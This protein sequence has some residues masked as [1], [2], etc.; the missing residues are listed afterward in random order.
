MKRKLFFKMFLKSFLFTFCVALIVLF[1]FIRI[2]KTQYLENINHK[3]LNI[4]SAVETIIQTSKITKNSNDIQRVITSIDEKTGIRITIINHNGDVLADS[5]KNAEEMENHSD[6]PEFK[7]ALE[8]GYGNAIRWSPTIDSYMIYCAKNIAENSIVIRASIPVDKAKIALIS[9]K[10]KILNVVLIALFFGIVFS[11]LLAK[12]ATEPIYEILDFTEE[13]KSGRTPDIIINNKIQEIHKIMQNLTNF[14]GEMANFAK[15]E[16][17]VSEELVKFI[18]LVNFPIG[19]IDIKGDVA[20]SNSYF[21]EI[22]EIPETKGLWWEKIKNFDILKIIREVN[23]TKKTIEREIKIKDKT[24]LCKSTPLEE[25]EQILVVLIDISTIKD[26]QERK[27]DF[28]IAVSHELKTPLTAIKGY[29]ETIEENI[30]N[31]EN[32]K[33]L[34]IVKHHSERLEK[35]V[36]DLITLAQ[37]ENE[38]PVVEFKKVDII[39]IANNAISLFSKKAMEKGIKIELIYNNIPEINGDAF[40]LEQMFI[41]LIDN[42]IRFTEKGQITISMNHRNNAV[43]IKIADTGIGIPPQHIPKIF[44]RFYVVDKARSRQTGGTGLGLSIVKHIVLLHN[45]TIN[46]ESTPGKG[47]NFII[48]LPA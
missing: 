43:I 35:I 44:E 4:V 26:I 2:L 34:D 27:K 32:K 13:I 29:I 33:F 36:E 47:T 14:A 19:I 16:K 20:L 28:V 31:P 24:F 45:G 18:E 46:V 11:L 22:L 17:I 39:N 6:R 12:F 8:I 3:L 40:R 23:E 10:I 21:K 25:Y 1:F 48:K 42:A 9:Q 38:K 5:R 30:E 15:K 41:N 37:L 7:Q